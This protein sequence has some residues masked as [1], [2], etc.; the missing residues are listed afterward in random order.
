MYREIRIHTFSSHGCGT[1]TLTSTTPGDATVTASYT[2]ASGT[3]AGSVT[4]TFFLPSV[5]VNAVPV[6][7]QANWFAAAI[8]N[9]GTVD[10]SVSATPGVDLTGRVTWS[11]ANPGADPTVFSV[12]QTTAGET[13]LTCTVQGNVSSMNTAVTIAVLSVSS[14]GNAAGLTEI[15]T[16]NGVNLV[17]GVEIGDSLR[18]PL[19]PNSLIAP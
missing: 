7:G 5:S 12:D 14:I 10:A 18:C 9:A 3:H 1:V 16:A 4:V 8:A 15:D 6:P 17:A 13:A 11:P 2:D 19:F